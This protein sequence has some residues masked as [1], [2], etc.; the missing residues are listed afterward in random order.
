M[1]RHRAHYDVIVIIFDYTHT[2]THPYICIYIY[3]YIVFRA[4]INDDT[5]TKLWDV[6]THQ[7]PNY[8]LNRS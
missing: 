2:Y 4:W 8:L 1:K 6:I 7:Y 5:H 3:T